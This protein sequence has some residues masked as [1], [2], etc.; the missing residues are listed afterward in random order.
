MLDLRCRAQR[1]PDARGIDAKGARQRERQ[2]RIRR[3]LVVD[4]EV[5]LAEAIAAYSLSDF[6][7]SA[8]AASSQRA[9]L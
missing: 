8:A 7:R 4:D 3:V 2:R 1:G 5:D 9:R 6:G